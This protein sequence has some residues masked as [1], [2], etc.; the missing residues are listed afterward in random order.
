MADMPG[1]LKTLLG[2]NPAELQTTIEGFLGAI[3]NGIEGNARQ[4]AELSD[5]T[6]KLE[7][8]VQD[9]LHELETAVYAMIALMREELDPASAG[10]KSDA[11]Q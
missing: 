7:T 6:E 4:I 9:T 8:A 2:I 10:R 3:K 5:R 1:M 11:L